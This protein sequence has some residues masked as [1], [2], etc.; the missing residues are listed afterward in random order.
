MKHTVAK[1]S[2]IH[3]I[4]EGIP[5]DTNTR[6]ISCFTIKGKEQF[7]DENGFPRTHFENNANTHA[8]L[9]INGDSIRHLIKFSSTGRIFNPFGLYDETQRIRESRH[10]ARPNWKWRQVSAAVFSFYIEF[11]KTRNTSFLVNAERGIV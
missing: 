9:V 6:V 4:N 8:K 2:D 1:Q 10:A 5:S 7:I 11:L 3:V